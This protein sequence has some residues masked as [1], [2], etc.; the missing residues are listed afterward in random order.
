MTLRCKEGDLALVLHDE[1]G[2]EPNIGRVV[3]VRG[4]VQVSRRLKLPCWLVLPVGPD[5]LW[6][7]PFADGPPHIEFV[8]R[9]GQVE[10]ADAWL[11]PI[12]P[13]AELDGDEIAQP[14]AWEAERGLA[15]SELADEG[16]S[17]P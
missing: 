8:S 16:G 10:L 9:H 15:G 3:E 4:P 5:R 1:P 7:I 6:Y 12:R 13:P 11:L 2:G 14:E 17:T